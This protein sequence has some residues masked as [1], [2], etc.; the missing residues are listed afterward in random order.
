MFIRIELLFPGRVLFNEHFYNTIV[1]AHGF[2]IVFFVVIPILIGGF[3][4]WL[5]PLML[6][7]PDLI[8]PRTN[9]LSFWLVVPAFLIL[10]ISLFRGGGAAT[11]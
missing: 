2:I 1:T 6:G 4:N 11:G 7:T 9:N 10:V 8:Y 5:L 3:G